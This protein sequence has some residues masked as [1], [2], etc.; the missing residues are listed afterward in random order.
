M[1]KPK[2]KHLAALDIQKSPMLSAQAAP[3][4]SLS[5][6]KRESPLNAEASVSSDEDHSPNLDGNKDRTGGTPLASLSFQGGGHESVANMNPSPLRQDDDSHSGCSSWVEVRKQRVVIIIPPLP[7]AKS[8]PPI[9]N[10]ACARKENLQHTPRKNREAVFKNR[11]CVKSPSSKVYGKKASNSIRT[12]ETES[13]GNGSGMLE[14]IGRDTAPIS[15]MEILLASALGTEHT[16]WQDRRQHHIDLL[17]SCTQEEASLDTAD[18]SI[19]PKS[20]LAKRAVVRSKGALKVQCKPAKSN[21]A[22]RIM[23]SEKISHS[24]SDRG[25]DMSFALSINQSIKVVT[26]K[27]HLEKA[28][29]LKQWLCSLGLVQFKEAFGKRS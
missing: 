10:L 25:I 13:K 26:L 27:K 9:K 12:L 8:K 1:A 11:G 22:K 14:A 23:M 7:K 6:T 18:S 19:Q 3:T 4:R 16:P 24:N 20:S 29:G 28:G 2:R 17:A 21:E 15:G 5:S